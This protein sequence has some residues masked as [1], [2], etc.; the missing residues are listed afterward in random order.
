NKQQTTNN[1]QQTTNNK[2]QDDIYI[3]NLR[4]FSDNRFSNILAEAVII[5]AIVSAAD[6][7]F[8][9]LWYQSNYIYTAAIAHYHN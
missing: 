2:Q 6:C 1:K 8:N 4:N 7:Q 9:I 5:L 3:N